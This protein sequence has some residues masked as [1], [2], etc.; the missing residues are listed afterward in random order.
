[1]EN[2]LLKKLREMEPIGFID[3][4]NDLGT[5][6]Y[7]TFRFDEPVSQLTDSQG[8]VYSKFWQEKIEEMRQVYIDWQNYLQNVESEVTT[9]KEEINQVVETYLT[10]GFRFT[11]FEDRVPYSLKMLRDNWQRSNFLRTNNPQV[12][13]KT[14][15]KKGMVQPQSKLAKIPGAIRF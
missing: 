8:K 3:P 14:K 13:L 12:F 15:L 2:P 11:E 5:F 9:Q 4:I 7:F 10:L 1:M 6:N